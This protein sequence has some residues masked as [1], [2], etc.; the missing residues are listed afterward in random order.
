MSS[1]FRALIRCLL[2]GAGQ[3]IGPCFTVAELNALSSDGLSLLRREKVLVRTAIPEEIS[4]P[5]HGHVAVTKMG[6]NWYLV[7]LSNPALDWIKVKTD[8]IERVRLSHLGLLKWVARECEIAGDPS[9]N[10]PI[11]TM[12]ATVLSGR[13]FRVLYYPGPAIS[14]RLLAA[15]QMLDPHD[16]GIPQLLLLPFTL[17]LTVH[18]LSRLEGRGLFLIHL[19]LITTENGIDLEL[20]TLPETTPARKSGYYFQRVRGSKSWEVGFNT[21]E[22]KA[23]SNIVAMSRLWVLIRNPYKIFTASLLT[24]ELNGLSNDRKRNGQPDANTKAPVRSKGTRGRSSTDLTDK[25]RIEAKQICAEMMAAKEEYGAESREFRDAEEAWKHFSH[26]H[27]LAEVH[28]GVV[29]REG[30]DAAKE[31]EAVRRSIDRWIDSNLGGELDALARH[32]DKCVTR[33]VN[34]SYD[35]P[36][37]LPWRT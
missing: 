30:D 37:E 26:K 4:H 28:G 25:Q 20:A 6:G 29:K 31:A 35:P 3:T 34:F 16:G 27:G 7:P 9:F 32:L 33:G 21:S 11:W 14:D 24:N 12:G 19:Y 22:P 23:V 36:E 2:D 1:S 10:G 15:I 8:E 18:E 13:R 5:S 17:S